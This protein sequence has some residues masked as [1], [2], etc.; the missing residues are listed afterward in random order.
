MMSLTA[1]FWMWIIT[2]TIIG[3]M[4]GWAKEVLVTF[5]M[6]LALFL[7]TLLELYVP[8]LSAALAS[9][10]PRAQF[11]VKV[12][13]LLLLVFFGYESPALSGVVQAKVRREKFQDVALGAVLGALNGYMVIGTIWY[14]LDFTGYPLPQVLPPADLRVLGYIPYLPPRLIGVPY[15]YFAVGLAFVFV[16]IVFV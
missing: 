9:Q 4:R 2:F 5:A 11:V 8:G 10:S 15:L 14:Y 6:V 12:A 3:G 13:L 1:V 16:I 7:N